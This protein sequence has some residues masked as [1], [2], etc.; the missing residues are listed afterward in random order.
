MYGYGDLPALPVYLS[1]NAQ[2]KL[3]TRDRVGNDCVTWVQVFILWKSFML[4]TWKRFGG[5]MLPNQDRHTL[6]RSSS[7]QLSSAHTIGSVA[8]VMCGQHKR[9]AETCKSKE[10]CGTTRPSRVEISQAIQLH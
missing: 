2:S 7:H 1:L 4:G 10:H 3:L 6:L 8:Q 9:Q 5:G